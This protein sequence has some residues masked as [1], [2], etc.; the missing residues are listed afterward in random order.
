MVAR[1][2]TLKRSVAPFTPTGEGVYQLKCY[3]YPLRIVP[4]P[5]T[6]PSQCHCMSKQYV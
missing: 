4:D 3:H 1:R 6:E 5:V 2:M